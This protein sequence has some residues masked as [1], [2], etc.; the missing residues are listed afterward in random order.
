MEAK[1]YPEYTTHYPLLI[2]SITKRPL[3]FYRTRR[4]EFHGLC[5]WV[6]VCDG[7]MR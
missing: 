7:D 4:A 3:N 6:N 1:S 5:P 2:K